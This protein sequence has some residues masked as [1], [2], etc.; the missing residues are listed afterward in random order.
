MLSLIEEGKATFLGR[1]TA[2]MALEELHACCCPSSRA[3]PLHD[4]RETR[5]FSSGICVGAVRTE[6]FEKSGKAYSRSYPGPFAANTGVC[7]MLYFVARWQPALDIYYYCTRSYNS[8]L[9]RRRTL[10]RRTTAPRLKHPRMIAYHRRRTPATACA[11]CRQ[12]SRAWKRTFNM[13]RTRTCCCVV[14]IHAW[15]IQQF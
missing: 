8:S 4:I 1:M 15:Y 11:P 13:L 10:A 2:T 14:A 5:P 7:S 9:L 6:A 3:S 12:R